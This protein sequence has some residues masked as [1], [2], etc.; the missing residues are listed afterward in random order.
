[1]LIP[2]A[3]GHSVQDAHELARL[4]ARALVRALPALASLE[5]EKEKRRGRLFVDHLQSYVGKSLACAY[6]VRAVD[7]A[8]V[9]TP[10]EWS[11]LSTKLAPR[12]FNLRTVRQ[13]ID[14]RGDLAASLLT[15][16]ANIGPA[17]AALRDVT[18]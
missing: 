15:G 3:P 9:S 5:S 10:L 13:R 2:L 7:G 4:L 17:I 8:P 18:R 12:D 6:T 11:E 14:A 16:G 1:M